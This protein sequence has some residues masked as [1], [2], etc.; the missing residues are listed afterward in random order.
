MSGTRRGLVLEG[1]GLRGLFTAGVLDAWMAAGVEVDGV[2]G[3]SAGACFGCNWKSGQAGRAIRY[4]LR[5]AKEWRYCSWR[6]WALTGDLFG[7]EFCYRRV[8]LE[9]DPFDEAAYAANPAEFHVVATDADTG[10]PAYWKLDRADGDAF[11][12]FRASA[13]MP[14][15]SRPVALDGRRYLDGG[16][17]D[18]IPLAYFE[19]LGFGRNVVV[20]TRERSYRKT[21]PGRLA[22][23][24]ARLALRGLPAVAAA[25]GERWRAYNRTL[26]LLAAREREG[27]AMVVSPPAPLDIGRVCHDR[28]KM[29]QAYGTGRATGEASA[30][31]VKAFLAGA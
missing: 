15:V 6:S 28:A 27:A 24:V 9:L 21:P 25:L 7:A 26:E 29:R 4:N 10:R 20:T 5:F 14:L 2:V 19:G 3:V 18:A 30:E 23:R 16:L 11:E 22:L 13:S 12:R 1:G 17:S 8:P 31:R